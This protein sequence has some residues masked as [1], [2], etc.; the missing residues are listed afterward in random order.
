MASRKK[1][2]SLRSAKRMPTNVGLDYFSEHA[3]CK[4]C[5]ETV[6]V[7]GGLFSRHGSLYSSETPCLGSGMPVSSVDRSHGQ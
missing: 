1:F 2:F 3:F 6:G 4:F 5:D 7:V